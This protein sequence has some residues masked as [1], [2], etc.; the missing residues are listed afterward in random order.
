MKYLL[1]G[2]RGFIG[3]WVSKTL[4]Q[5][6]HEVLVLSN[7]SHPSKLSDGREYIYGDVRYE[8]DVD[9]AVKLVDCVIHLAARINVDRS[10]ESARPFFDTNILGT[11]N[12]LEACRKFKKKMIHASTSEAL[13]SM[14]K[15]YSSKFIKNEEI[16]EHLN[17]YGMS[18][19]HPYSPDNPY[20]ATKAAADMLCIGWYKSYDVDVTLLRSFNVCGT[21]QAY[22]NEGG[23]IPKCIK[24]IINNENPV[25]FGAGDQTRD[26]VWVGDV[27]KAY[28]LLSQAD[29]AGQIYHTGTGREVS[30][31]YVAETLIK[32]S[33]KDLRID[34]VG[35]RP[36]EVKRLKCDASKIKALSWQSTKTIEDV[37]EDMYD[38][39]M[40]EK[41]G[42]TD[43]GNS[44]KKVRDG[45]EARA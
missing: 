6:G 33:G 27:A 4:E 12:V 22:D 35:S 15:R 37:L 18:E 2:G 1:T 8:Y 5:A 9:K 28:L 29:Y 11:F 32:I 31:K 41:V 3:S 40:A 10:R 25:I 26:Y 42:V 20:G 30:I 44:V 43:L 36:K 45:M 19:S 13:G 23:F 38:L 34:F 16:F 14:Q 24:K 17:F 7:L 21:G 39:A